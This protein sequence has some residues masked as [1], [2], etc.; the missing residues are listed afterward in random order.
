MVIVKDERE[1]EAKQRGKSTGEEMAGR[2]YFT[3]QLYLIAL[4][5]A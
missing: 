4:I 2:K 1:K 5:Q 3:E